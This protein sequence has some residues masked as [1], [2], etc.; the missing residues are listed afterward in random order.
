[1]NYRNLHYYYLEYMMKELKLL[2]KIDFFKIN[3]S[4]ILYKLI[5]YILYFKRFSII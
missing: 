4:T 5:I 2:N 1:M 3:Y